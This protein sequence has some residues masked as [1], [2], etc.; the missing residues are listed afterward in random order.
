MS[1]PISSIRNLGPAFEKAC[2]RVGIRSAQQLRDMGPDEAYARVLRA[3]T[4]PHFIGYYVLVMGLQGRPWND[5][6]GDE[7]KALRQRFDAIK[8]SVTAMPETQ[9][10]SDL[11]AIG[12]RV[13]PDDLKPV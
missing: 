7:K 10:I 13:S 9:M 11:D 1:D 2:A 4:R 8:A 12:V 3:G 6:K 5:C